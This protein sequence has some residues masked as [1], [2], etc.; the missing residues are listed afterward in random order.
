MSDHSE[1]AS[2]LGERRDGA[3]DVLRLVGGGHLR[4]DARLPARTTGNEKPIT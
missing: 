2:D 3:F 1:L 4:A